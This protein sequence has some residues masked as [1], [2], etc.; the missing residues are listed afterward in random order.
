MSPTPEEHALRQNVVERIRNVVLKLW[1]E[2]RVEIFGSFRTGLYLPTSDIDLVVIGNW[3]NNILP[4]RTLEQALMVDEIAKA[5]S[6]QVLDKASVSFGQIPLFFC[7]FP[8][9]TCAIFL[10]LNCRSCHSRVDSGRATI[11]VGTLGKRII[12]L[13]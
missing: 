9:S 5:S 8:P 2:S 3:D 4:L 11:V 7:Y 13:M 1:P 10:V 6:I 12:P